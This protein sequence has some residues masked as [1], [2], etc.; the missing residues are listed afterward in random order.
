MDAAADQAASR[1]MS[2]DIAALA[3]EFNFYTKDSA[4]I[5]LGSLVTLR[6]KAVPVAKNLKLGSRGGISYEN[7]KGRRVYMKRADKRKCL[8]LGYVP[9]S[10]TNICKHIKVHEEDLPEALRGDIPKYGRFYTGP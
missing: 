7:S 6:G 4:N 5:G 8:E 1:T 10:R 2:Q 3:A 9:G